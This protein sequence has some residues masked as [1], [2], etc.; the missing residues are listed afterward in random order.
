MAS[1]KSGGISPDDKERFTIIVMIGARTSMHFF[2]SHVGIG[3]SEQDLQGEAL[4]SLQTSS[5]EAGVNS[6]N[7]SERAV[8]PHK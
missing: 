2:V 6:F 1:L 8:K 7:I 4:I 5:T 3:S